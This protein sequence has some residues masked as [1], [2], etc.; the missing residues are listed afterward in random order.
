MRFVLFGFAGLLAAVGLFLLYVLGR[1][2]TLH[3]ERTLAIAAPPARVF[4][5]IDDLHQWPRWWKNERLDGPRQVTYSGAPRGV[6]AEL[7]TAGKALF[8]FRITRAVPDREVAVAV[9]GSTMAIGYQLR[10]V[11]EP[12]STGCSVTVHMD[13]RLEY[14]EKL[15]DT[16]TRGLGPILGEGYEHTLTELRRAAEAG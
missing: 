7:Q 12:T 11:I 8:T 3:V 4:A 13:R 16:V 9:Q 2:S 10:F 5:L 1:S 14:W 6:G 15:L